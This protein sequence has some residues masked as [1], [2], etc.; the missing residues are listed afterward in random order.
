MSFSGDLSNPGIELTAPSQ[1]ALV[2]KNL[3][4]N[5]G[6]KRDSSSIPGLGRS[7]GRGHGNLLQYSCLENPHRQGSL[8]G[9]SPKGVRESDTTEMT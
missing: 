2:T 1:V 7:S 4:A 3:P 6:V 9:Y 8:V 5:A